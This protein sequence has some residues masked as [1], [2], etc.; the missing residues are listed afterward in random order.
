MDVGAWLRGL[1]FGQ[2]EAAFRDN[3]IDADV[4]R[5]LTSEDLRELGVKSVGERRRLLAAIAALPPQASPDATAAATPLSPERSAPDASAE[6]RQMTVMFCDLVGSTALSTRLD[7]EDM[8][9]V[10]AAF[11]KTCA[12]AIKDAGGYLAKFLGDGALAY[13]GYPAAHEDDAE[14]AV[15]AGLA[16]VEAVPRISAPDGTTLHVRVGIA[17]GVVV[18]GDLL[19]FGESQERGVVGDTPNLA[20]RLQGVAA[21]IRSSSPSR[22]SACLATCSTSPTLA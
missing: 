7:P 13:F 1:G 3:G 8:R 4:L 22:H 12:D 6:R 18:V 21:P 14:R 19:G 11:Q 2:Y 20:S 5:S 16:L 15:R 10:I 9:A 17:T